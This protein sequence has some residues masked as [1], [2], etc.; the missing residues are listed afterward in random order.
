MKNIYGRR[1]QFD[2]YYILLC[3]LVEVLQ[4][5][6]RFKKLHEW[7]SLMQDNIRNVILIMVLR[8]GS[9]DTSHLLALS[10]HISK[11]LKID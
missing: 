5:M 3:P 6:Q 7:C 10:I 4:R 1:K 9:M 11:S 2:F 8:Y